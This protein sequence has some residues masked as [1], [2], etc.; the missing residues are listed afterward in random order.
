[1]NNTSPWDRRLLWLALPVALFLVLCY[2][3]FPES[4]DDAFITLRYSKN[5][6][7][8]NGPVFNIGEHVEGFSNPFWM[9]LLGAMGSAGV[10]M[11][12]GM[13]LLGILSGVGT[14]LITARAASKWFDSRAIG[15]G[16]ALL[17][18]SSSFFALWAADGLETVF[19]AFAVTLLLWSATREAGEPWGVGAIASIVALTRPE[20]A[21]FG[22]VIVAWVV[23]RR[24]FW[25]AAKV[26]LP[27]FA[28]V[29]GYEVFR[30][31][32]FGEWLSNT[33]AA[34]VHTNRQSLTNAG[35]Y[36]WLFN[37][38]SA[39]FPLPLA[40]IGTFS[41][42]RCPPIVLVTLFALA[43]GVFLLVSGGDFMF[44]YRFIMPV[45]PCLAILA[46]AAALSI[47][48]KPENALAALTVVATISGAA[49]YHSRQP[50]D[51][52]TD[53]L[54][55]RASI[56]FSIAEYLRANTTSKDTVL[57]SEA[58]IIPYFV[59]ARV[60]D[61]LGLTS[62]YW[63]VRNRDRSLNIEHLFVNKPK[64]VILSFKRS[65]ALGV[66]P[67]LYEDEAIFNSHEFQ[68]NYS[69]VKR[70][71][72]RKNVSLLNDIYYF[73]APTAQDIYFAVFRRKG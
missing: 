57:L 26:A 67:R 11:P 44:A 50:V 31:A 1:M 13:K 40:F 9:V 54:T 20:G 10:P 58:G 66:T 38:D 47:F 2:A 7:L 55:R 42:L 43:Q 48:K 4:I 28:A 51:L 6:M 17:V 52:G 37:R 71:D 29:A 60:D 24:G 36:L 25:P 30:Q 19:Y 49:Q 62:P 53:N 63:Y 72:I 27:F 34:K 32:Y 12:L 15:F 3:F 35:R 73:Y 68:S 14:I 23:F 16:A 45:V 64:Y 39:Y 22:V 8:G 69:E 21:M 5:L 70:F 46:C 59:D 61:Y 41:G 65:A 56:H 18:A 33:A